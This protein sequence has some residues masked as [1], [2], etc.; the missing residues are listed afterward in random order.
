M[1]TQRS[2]LRRWG[3]MPPAAAALALATGCS[4]FSLGP[5]EDEAD[6]VEATGEAPMLA[7]MVEDGDLPPLEERLPEN[8]VIVE[9]N[10]EIGSY[11]GTW[12]TA[13][14]GIGDWP[15]LGRTVGYENLTRWD[16][17]WEEPIPN[18]AESWEYN[19]DATEIHFTLREGLKWSDG[20]PFTTE[21]IEFAMTDLYGDPNLSTD[22]HSDFGTIDVISETE[23]TVSF[24]EP[25]SLW[26]AYDL[27]GYQ[28]VQKPKH[29][30][31]QFHIDYNE[32]ADDLAEEEGY[33]GWEEM[34]DD[35]G[36][37][38]DSAWWWQ[39]P[40][41]PTMYPWEVVEPLADSGQMVL[42]RNPY[43]WK[44]D[45]EGNQL[46]YLD[47][48]VFDIVQDEEVMLTQALNG[49]IDFHTRH[50]N[51]LENR[52][53]LADHREDGD[54]DFVETIPGEMNTNAIAFNLTHEDDALRE[55]F[56]DRDFRVAMSHG[57]NRQDIID[58][59]YQEQGEPW[60][61][62]PRE[63]SEF[64]HEE[65]AKQY[66]EYDVDLANEI[67][68]DA[69]YDERNSDG[70]RLSPDGDPV[71][72][73]LSVATDFRADIVDSMEMVVEMWS[74]LDVDVDLD[75]QNRDLMLDR[76]E[77]NDHDAL[78]WSGD[79]GLMDAMYDGRWYLPIHSGE[80]AYAIPW[81]QW[82]NTDGEDERSIEPPDDVQAHLEMY[83]EL[84]AEPTEEARIEK[85]HEILDES[86]EQ[87]YAIGI[88]LSPPGYGIVRN[89]FG[90]VPD[91]IIEAAVYNTPGPT[92]PEQ[93]FIR[94]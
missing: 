40:D 27:I 54:Y 33:S 5:D 13:T 36:G 82:D 50:F 59:V 9:P 72:F 31:E 83:E 19:E 3:L 37:I 89:D 15:W 34:I 30:L 47:S 73:Q 22:A 20:E 48:V 35:K 61:L 86:A 24:E 44:V 32:D 58:V 53:T 87:F 56:N 51:V 12:N 85:M 25:N 55:I 62:A 2:P 16:V 4:F 52:S 11:G 78:V 71:S 80:S 94:D 45:T 60:Q 79:A 74:D 42:E 77:D 6:D 81:A 76:R 84:E 90:N 66:T 64:Y 92:N 1:H 46:P 8:P 18:L 38:T 23:F 10:E 88:S 43:Y 49:E 67:L 75:T 29:Y 14:T 57:I 63:E 65:L 41:L 68:D 70:I 91:T 26:A 39:N 17:D 93:Y 28:I 69:G 21:D 7:Q